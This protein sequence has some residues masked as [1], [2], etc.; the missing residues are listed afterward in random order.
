MKI[1]GQQPEDAT[2][3]SIT[4]RTLFQG[5]S[6][7]ALVGIIGGKSFTHTTDSGIP[8]MPSTFAPA[9]KSNSF[10]DKFLW[11]CAT[12]GHQVEGNNSSSDLWALEHLPESI[13]KEP[14]GDACDHYHV[15]PQFISMLADLGFNYYR[16]A[17][18]WSRIEQEHGVF[19]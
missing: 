3:K 17:L 7:A 10:P 13:F 11:G 6:A 16:F 5:A 18:D 19:A 14:S 4:R 9:D 12:A 15:Y 1:A 2:A 8:S